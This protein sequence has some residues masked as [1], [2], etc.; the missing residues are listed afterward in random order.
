MKVSDAIKLR[1][2]IQRVLDSIGNTNGTRLPVTK[3][4]TGE[5]ALQ[6]WLWKFVAKIASGREREAITNAVK[7]GVLF[8][9]KKAP[10]PEGTLKQTYTSDVVN[11]NVLVKNASR[12]L[13]QEALKD[14]LRK[15]F[16]LT[17]EQI[18]TAFEMS[19]KYNAAPHEFSPVLVE[20]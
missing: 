11:V 20:E 9:H 7:A 3:S 2:N 12:S 1:S 5:A 8:D 4:N 18:N 16:K 10:L 6:Y 17:Q 19:M 13:D 14:N 15:K